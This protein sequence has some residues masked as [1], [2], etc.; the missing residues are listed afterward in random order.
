MGLSGSDNQPV[1]RY[2][3]LRTAESILGTTIP[4]LVGQQRLSWKLLWYGGF[5]ASQAKQQGGGGS[6]LGKSGV[7]Y[8]YSASVIGSVCMGVCSNFLGVWDSQGRY[9]MDTTTEGVTLPSSGSIIYVPQNQ[10]NFKQ[11]LGVGVTT[12]YSQVANDYGSNGPITY[13]GTQQVPLQYTTSATPAAGQYTI[14]N[15]PVSLS[16]AATSIAAATANNCVIT[17]TFTGGAAN[18]FNGYVA[19]V[20]GSN[21]PINN[22]QF[23]VVGST[24]TTLTV[25]NPSAV[26]DPAAVITVNLITGV[27]VYVFNSAQAGLTIEV[28]YVAYQYHI[29]ENELDVVPP[30]GGIVVQYQA[31]QKCTP[32]SV[33][34][35]PSGV[36]LSQTTN[37]AAPAAN[38]T[39]YYNWNSG[40]V[41]FN[42]TGSPNDE[43]AA[44]NITYIYNNY[45]TDSNSNSPNT[46][47]LSFYGGDLGQQPW[48]FIT[49]T[50][51]TILSLFGP[52]PSL[53]PSYSLGYS[54]IAYVAAGALYLGYSPV[55]PQFNFEIAGPY[56]FGNGIPDCNPATAIYALLVNPSYKLNFPVLNISSTLTTG[57]SSALNMWSANNFFISEVLDSQTSLMNI[58]SKWCEAGQVYISWDE[59]LLKFIPLSDTTAVANGAVYIPP[60]QPIIDLDDND[61][62][63]EK[64]EDPIKVEQTPWQNRWNK[65]QV[66]WSVRTNDYNEDILQVQDEASV[67]LYGLMQESAQ[68]WQFICTEPAAQFA[69][70]MRLQR[71]SAIYTTYSFTLKANFAFLSPGDIITITDGLL[72]TAG[73]MFGRTPCRITKMTDDPKK[74]VIIEA[75]NFPWSVG[76]SLLKNVQAQIPANTNDGPQQNPGDTVPIIFEVPNRAQQWD[77]DQIYIFANG[78]NVNWGGFQVWV[79]YNGIDYNYYQQYTK[80]GRIGTTLADYPIVSWTPPASTGLPVLDSTDVLT[81]QMNQTD[82]QLLTVTSSDSSQGYVTLSGLV[83]EGA[84]TPVTETT[85]VGNNSGSS[86]GGSA[87]PSLTGTGMNTNVGAG[88]YGIFLTG[89]ITIYFWNQNGNA[90][91]WQPTGNPSFPV[92]T[93]SAVAT[94]T[95]P[96]LGNSL[97][98]NQGSIPIGTQPME[99]ATLSS[100]GNITGN[101]V[102]SIG[103]FSADNEWC[104]ALLFELIIPAAGNYTFKSYHDDGLF[105]GF[106]GGATRVSGPNQVY[107]SNTPVSSYPVLGGIDQN[108]PGKGY[109][110]TYVIN[111]PSAGTYS[112]ELD[113][114]QYDSYQS[115]SFS[116]GDLGLWPYMSPSLWVN[117]NNVTSSGSYATV[118]LSTTVTS[119][120]AETSQNLDTTK[121]G[122]NIAYTGGGVIVGVQVTF[123]S[124]VSSYSPSSSANNPNLSCQ[125]IYQ[126]NPIGSP[127]QAWEGPYPGFPTSTTSYTVGSATT[128]TTWGLGS[129][130]SG[131]NTLTATMINDP[132]FGVRFVASVAASSSATDTINVNDVSVEIFWAPAGAAANWVNPQDVNSSVSY[133]YSP[134]TTSASTQ[135]LNATGCG[136][137]QPFGF[138]LTGVAVQV[139]AY[140]SVSGSTLSAQLLYGNLR[141][142]VQ[143]AST[144]LSL[145][146]S[147]ANYTFGGQGQLWGQTTLDVDAVNDSTFGVALLMGGQLGETVYLNNVQI[148]LYGYSTYNLEL[149]SYETATLVAGTGTTGQNT[150]QLTNIQ[151]GVY[152]SYPCDHPAGATFVRM[153]QASLIYTV[154]PTYQGNTIWFKFLSFNA[155]GNQL[156]A[157]SAVIGYSLTIGGLAPGAI[158]G[159]SGA[160]LTGIGIN[161]VTNS[162]LHSV[163]ALSQT[164]EII[165]SQYGIQNIPAGYG[166]IGPSGPSGAG[167]SS[168]FA[169]PPIWVPIISGGGGGGGVAN[170]YVITAA[171]SLTASVFDDILCNTGGGSF[172]VTFPLAA[173]SMNTAIAVQKNSTDTNTVTILPTGSDTVQ[174]TN[175]TTLSYFGD[176]LY[177]V[178]DGV[179]NWA[180]LCGWIQPANDAYIYIPPIAGV[181]LSSQELWY[182]TPVR[183][184]TLPVNL[185]GSHAGARTAPTGNVQVTIKKNG[186]SIG[187]VNIAGSATTAT[188][189]FTA[190]VT[191]N[192]TTD[193]ISFVAPASAD[194]TFAGF[195]CDLLATRAT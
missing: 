65:V 104:M 53:A 179:S 29:Q 87:G 89:T 38:T 186:S 99:W 46:L 93:G 31:F 72:G 125:L 73:T 190:A 169:G 11:D 47:N 150:Y 116:V 7:Q 18:A 19:T 30:G 15:T 6:G 68:S 71:Y 152:G 25:V 159:D 107:H 27:P 91:I 14:T 111:F 141:I 8:V 74:G 42:V 57:T 81:V 162:V 56:Q 138:I 44:V 4:I 147:P 180:I 170:L 144:P 94:T 83:S 156:Q 98:F 155:Y 9:A 2:N 119:T 181:Y 128:L 1:T 86:S 126:G 58:I 106:N 45:T 40:N 115:L 121:Y 48:A 189:T 96:T 135:W 75:E 168:Q 136:F 193:T 164:H 149:I 21:F 20:I 64:N 148:T 160:L 114:F 41:E 171:G 67:Q 175:S 51:P 79:S 97:L 84:T 191:I 176:S 120:V 102:L 113:Y 78:Q 43:G 77:G 13:T 70:N 117:A 103:P 69:A 131:A 127:A 76:A 172:N 50:N 82:S 165:N 95:S 118:A 167:T 3:G 61:F 112:G 158:D 88:I 54:E 66:R 137:T 24:A 188:F 143:T 101:G 32:V 139:T 5:T 185:T 105:F 174:M 154:D 100:T 110:D 34:Y 123:N 26:A 59:G 33:T 183:S 130:S 109:T 92:S 124:Y 134:L 133:A 192:G 62:V 142:G 177:F 140:G 55:L 37:G 85:Q 132:S 146:T 63:V 52:S 12:S 108:A 49:A 90:G 194:A 16:F 153:D 182:A 195:W 129:T 166:L 184:F 151:R 28:T 173:N 122:F 145:T 187:T 22:G 178:S 80:P 60:T 23:N 35:Y 163:E 36:A 10:A 157:L 39:G 17:G 161:P